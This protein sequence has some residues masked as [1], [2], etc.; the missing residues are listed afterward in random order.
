M[1]AGTG[2]NE[3]SPIIN[4][5]GFRKQHIPLQQH[6][7]NSL[8]FTDLIC[9]TSNIFIPSCAMYVCMYVNA[10]HDMVM[11]A[12][13]ERAL[14]S[15]MRNTCHLYVTLSFNDAIASP[16]NKNSNI[17]KRISNYNRMISTQKRTPL[18]IW[19]RQIPSQHYTL[20]D[21]DAFQRVTQRMTHTTSEGAHISCF[22]DIPG[23]ARSVKTA[24]SPTCMISH[25]RWHLLLWGHLQE[26]TSEAGLSFQRTL[27]RDAQGKQRTIDAH[28]VTNKCTILSKIT[29]DNKQPLFIYQYKLLHDRSARTWSWVVLEFGIWWSLAPVL[30]KHPRRQGQTKL[31]CTK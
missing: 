19:R 3:C 9:W 1:C 11:L 22:N 10:M 30:Q 5:Y 18:Y 7:F 8:N 20:I 31:H 28:V 2:A 25:S 29:L 26:V 23:H 27:G 12:N 14:T 15:S 13:R 16:P 17:C 24:K 6:I 21:R 4:V